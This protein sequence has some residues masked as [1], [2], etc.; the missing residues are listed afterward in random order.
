MSQPDFNYN[1]LSREKW[2]S[3]RLCGQQIERLILKFDTGSV[4][5]VED[6]VLTGGTSG[7][8]AI[9][10]EVES[11]LLSGSWAGGDAAGYVWCKSAT[12][13]DSGDRAFDNDEAVTGSSGAAFVMDG[14]GTTVR[15]GGIL[16]P[17]HAIINKDG[18]Y[19]CSYHYQQ[20]FGN[21]YEDEPLDISED[22]GE[23]L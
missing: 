3:C 22:S 8:T 4:L 1:P 7:D 20:K 12:G 18:G 19:Y 16:H 21:E 9:V 14:T 17:G 13:K 11:P 6:E 15:T 2:Y 10:C 23:T 5:P